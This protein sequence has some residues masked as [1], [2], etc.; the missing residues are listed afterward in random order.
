LLF[1]SLLFN[2]IRHSFAYTWKKG[3]QKFVR[4][5]LFKESGSFAF[6]Y[7]SSLVLVA[8]FKNLLPCSDHMCVVRSPA[9]SFS[10]PVHSPYI[11]SSLKRGTLSLFLG[12]G[13]GEKEGKLRNNNRLCNKLLFFEPKTMTKLA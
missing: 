10:L 11:P 1:S 7:Q 5:R 13:E 3:A 2:S 6:T 8:H 12:D 4:S 9:P